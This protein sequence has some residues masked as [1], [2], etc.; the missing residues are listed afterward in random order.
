MSL[1]EITDL[2]V[3][4]YLGRG[5][6]L[7]AVNGVTLTVERGESVGL[8]G[9]SGC[10]KSTLSNVVMRILPAASGSVKFDGRNVLSFHGTQLL[11]FRRQAQMIFQDPYGS[12]NPRMSIGSALDE[13]LMVHRMGNRKKRRARVRELLTTVGLEPDYAERYPHE[14]S[15]G[16]RQRIGIARALALNPALIIADEPVSSLDVSVQVQILNL[17]KDLQQQRSLAYLFIAHDLAV[18]RYMCDRIFVMY[19]G[20][21][22]ESA[23]AEELFTNP[24]HP[25]TEALLAAIPD[26]EKSLR[27][28]KERTSRML[29]KGELPSATE[30]IT[31]CPFHSR[32]RHAKNICRTRLP[33]FHEVSVGHRSLCH[34]AETLYT[35]NG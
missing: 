18:V 26:V 30:S 5:K 6:T 15:G 19:L 32:C 16:Q 13:V 7:Y 20:R 35:P 28:R 17:M 9:E 4:F 23:L 21:I 10:G 22:M 33:E 3:L 25:Y 1:L 2:H 24:A 8:V 34:F 31:G 29:L 27:A 14:F 12:L 11:R